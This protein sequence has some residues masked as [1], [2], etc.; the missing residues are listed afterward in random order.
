[1]T[2][3]LSFTHGITERRLNGKLINQEMIV[4]C[5]YDYEEDSTD[6]IEVHI[7]QDGKHVAEI[8]KLLGKAE[9]DPLSVMIE[10]INWQEVAAN[11]KND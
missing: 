5:L 7:Y 8:S 11:K 2:E 1:M 3:K 9:G 6:D 4:K 10:A